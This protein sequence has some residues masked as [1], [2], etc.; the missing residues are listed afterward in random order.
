MC[1]SIGD[2]VPEGRVEVVGRREREGEAADEGL[3]RARR[4][5]RRRQA[6]AVTLKGELLMTQA[7]RASMAIKATERSS[8]FPTRQLPDRLLD[9]CAP[10]LPQS[11]EFPGAAGTL[12]CAPLHDAVGPP[13]ELQLPPHASA[14]ARHVTHPYLK[15]GG[16]PHLTPAASVANNAA[17]PPSTP[18]DA[19]VYGALVGHRD[20]KSEDSDSSKLPLRQCRHPPWISPQLT[21]SLD[22]EP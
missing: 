2:S 15:T 10:F 8:V 11:C 4:C 18:I 3:I 19:S 14:I 17:A 7:A 13:P 22:S 12:C 16:T 5:R 6:E 1:E 20:S 21:H 9:C